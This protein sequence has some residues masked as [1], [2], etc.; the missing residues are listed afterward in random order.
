MPTFPYS[1]IARAVLFT[2]SYFSVTMPS[3]RR[4]FARIMDNHRRARYYT[5]TASG[6][7]RLREETAGW[8][9]L[10]SAIGAALNTTS[11]EV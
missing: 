7:H 2:T 8:N 4:A 5:L 11:E 9:R 3:Y 1:A 6:R 10:V